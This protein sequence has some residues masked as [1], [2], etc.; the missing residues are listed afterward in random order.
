[1]STP[2]FYYPNGKVFPTYRIVLVT[3]LTL[4]I[5]AWV[6]TGDI[7]LQ[8][9]GLWHWKARWEPV[10]AFWGTTTVPA[11]AI[12]LFLQKGRWRSSALERKRIYRGCVVAFLGT[13]PLYWPAM[14]FVDFEI[15]GLGLSLGFGLLCAISKI[16]IWVF[17]WR[18]IVVPAYSILTGHPL[19]KN[20]VQQD[21]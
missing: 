15:T 17:W 9:I 16:C 20:I 21:S 2:T 4:C 8:I 11:I 10:E 12:W 14:I 13:I 6:T 5:V 1:M 18:L 19:H 7:V 3:I